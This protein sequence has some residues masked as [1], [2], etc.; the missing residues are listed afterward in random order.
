MQIRLES[1]RQPDV[2]Q[3]IDDLDAFQKPLYPPESHHGIDLNALDQPH[4]LF[5]VARSE[6]GVALGCGAMVLG[7]DCG[8]V[9]RMYVRPEARGQG[10]ARALLALVETAAIARGCTR[11]ALETGPLQPEALGLYARMGYEESGPFGDYAP[12]VHSVFMPKEV[13]VAA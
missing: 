6:Q 7:A 11:F 8:E 5:A 1:P 13:Q 10:L 3:L 12:D 2:V 9:K 4:V